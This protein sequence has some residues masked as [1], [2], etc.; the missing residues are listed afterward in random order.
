MRRPVSFRF[1][2]LVRRQLRA[3]LYAGPWLY[4]GAGA[5]G[6]GTHFG[7]QPSVTYQHPIAPSEGTFS[8]NGLFQVLL[9]ALGCRLSR[10]ENPRVGS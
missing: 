1:N 2:N 7:F 6:L 3:W 5:D 8:R 9:G 10:T 4:A